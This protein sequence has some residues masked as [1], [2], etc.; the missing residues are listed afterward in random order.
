[1]ECGQSE[2]LGAT[3]DRN[4]K[5]LEQDADLFASY[6]LMP[7][8]DFRSQF[9]GQRMTLELLQHCA[10]RYQVSSTAAALKW[11]E[12]T[13]NCAV[14]VVATNGFVLWCM[15]SKRAARSRLFYPSGM[16]LP[17][18]SLAAQPQL[19]LKAPSEGLELPAG[20]WSSTGHC[21][22]MAIFADRYEMTI[23]LIEFYD[24][25]PPWFEDEEPIEDAFDRFTKVS[26]RE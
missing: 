9:I 4:R 16:P 26:S 20:V 21:R 17:P 12:C 13:E 23:S 5:L 24:L 8:D 10:E 14:L 15:R 1:L 11:L 2:V 6:L 3:N 18:R 22:E 25:T 19:A 7:L